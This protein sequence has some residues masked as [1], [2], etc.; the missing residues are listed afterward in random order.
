VE[1][2][3]LRSNE[4]MDMHTRMAAAMQR[5]AELEAAMQRVG[6]IGTPIRPGAMDD[7]RATVK[8]AKP[9]KTPRMSPHGSARSQDGNHASIDN[10]KTRTRQVSAHG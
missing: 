6:G 2:G 9:R 1:V 7:T 3:S 4:L 8:D 10:V 5:I